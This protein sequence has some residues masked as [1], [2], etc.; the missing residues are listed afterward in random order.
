MP[1]YQYVRFLKMVLIQLIE[2][3]GGL[4]KFAEI[5]G[6][7]KTSSENF[8]NSICLRAFQQNAD[9]ARNKA[10]CVQERLEQD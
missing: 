7:W 1:P 6:S 9:S 5:I 2:T 10:P 4:N 3:L 8:S